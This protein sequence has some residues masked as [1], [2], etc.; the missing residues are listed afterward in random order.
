MYTSK[1][2]NN[3]AIENRKIDQEVNKMT[4]IY[5]SPRNP[6]KMVGKEVKEETKNGSGNSCIL[7]RNV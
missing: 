1:T 6:Q 5:K 2:H 4:R 7:T 3:L